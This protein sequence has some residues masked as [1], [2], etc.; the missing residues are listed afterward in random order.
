MQSFFDR[1]RMF[2]VAA[3]F[4]ITCSGT[5]YAAGGIETAGDVLTAALPAAAGGMILV[6]RDGTGAWQIAESAALTL[7]VTYLLKYTVAEERPNNEDRQS[8]PSAHTSVSFASAEFIRKRYGWEYG[9]PAYAAA[10]FVAYSR[11]DARQ[12]YAHDVIAGAAIGIASSYL[13]TEPYKG[14][15]IKP[16]ADRGYYGVRVSRAW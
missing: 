16:E 1:F 2:V 6:N 13:F 5:V 8:F 7:G 14:W 4:C 10:S 11:V 3:L 15:D 12:H 9:I